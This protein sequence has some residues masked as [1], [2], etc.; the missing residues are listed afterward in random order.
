MDFRRRPGPDEPDAQMIKDGQDHR[1]VFDA[2]YD[3]H[4]AL[5]LRTDQWIDFVDLLYQPGPV[6][7]EDFFIPLGFEDAG[8]SFVAAFLLP[9]G[10][11]TINRI[12][13]LSCPGS[14]FVTIRDDPKH[15]IFG[16]RSTFAIDFKIH[17]RAY[18]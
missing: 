10:E 2:A 3:P 8:D 13:Y 7:P 6:S 12:R 1:R 15:T 18:L 14:D 5:T 9:S 17:N 11:T 4:G 16:F